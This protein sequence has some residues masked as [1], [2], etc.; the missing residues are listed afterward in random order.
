MRLALYDVRGRRVRALVDGSRAAGVHRASWDGRD[1]QG[2]GAGA[3]VYLASI[4]IAG[5][6]AQ[7]KFVWLGR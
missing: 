6:K 5:L 2:A 1:Q 7:R 3:G 4:E